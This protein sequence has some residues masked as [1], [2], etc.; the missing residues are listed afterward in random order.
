MATNWA[1]RPFRGVSSPPADLVREELLHVPFT[2]LQLF[3]FDVGS[4]EGS[5]RPHQSV[6]TSA[7]LF[8]SARPYFADK[9]PCL[10]LWAGS[11]RLER[12]TGLGERRAQPSLP[13]SFPPPRPFSSNRMLT[14]SSP[15]L[16]RFLRVFK[17]R[18]PL[19]SGTS[20][21]LGWATEPSARASSPFCPALIYLFVHH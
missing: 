21:G 2:Q 15:H 13:Q 19:V 18:S 6:G 11:G 3:I 10:H 9:W 4:E 1:R 17:A 16:P 8:P 14:L 12:G 20:P 5:L 7:L